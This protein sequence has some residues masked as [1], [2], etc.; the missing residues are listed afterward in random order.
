M[1]ARGKQLG[2]LL[3]HSWDEERA[4]KAIWEEL[5]K[6]G[7]NIGPAKPGEFPYPMYHQMKRRFKA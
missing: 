2:E 4:V 6:E 5:G 1:M 7:A 3:F